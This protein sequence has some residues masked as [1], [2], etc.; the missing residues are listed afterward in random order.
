MRTLGH[1]ERGV[2]L[3]T[4]TVMSLV[5]ALVSLT[6]LALNVSETRSARSTVD[7]I[8]A[9]ELA[10][11]VFFQAH[12]R[13]V[14]GCVNC[15]V[16]GDCGSCPAPSNE[17]LDGKTFQITSGPVNPGAGPNGTDVWNVTVVY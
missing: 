14:E 10:V 11:G 6:I 9:G 17:N 15:P 8:R 12:Q 7:T 2:V 13:L 16:A 3:M 1:D 5:L 4:V